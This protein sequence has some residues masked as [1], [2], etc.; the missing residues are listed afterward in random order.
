M[1]ELADSGRWVWGGAHQVGAKTEPGQELQ[2]T[3]LQVGTV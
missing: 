1:P 2:G 3:C